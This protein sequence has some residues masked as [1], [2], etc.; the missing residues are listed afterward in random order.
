MTTVPATIERVHITGE[1]LGLLVAG[2]VS[3]YAATR[4]KEPW[5]KLALVAAG[6]GT[7]AV[8]GWLLKKKGQL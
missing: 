3:L 2:P 7:M 8:D 6:L 5:L 4:V 1:W